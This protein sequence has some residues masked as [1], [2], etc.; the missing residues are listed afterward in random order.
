MISAMNC[1]V[2][3]EI[4]TGKKPFVKTEFI[5]LHDTVVWPRQPSPLKN[6]P[7]NGYGRR[8]RAGEPLAH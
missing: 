8:A 7:P 6:R 3:S 1:S 5:E 4:Y 2:D